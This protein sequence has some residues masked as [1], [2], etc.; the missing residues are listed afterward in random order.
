MFA[1]S[2][3]SP[4]KA[5]VYQDPEF[6]GCGFVFDDEPSAST[7]SV[8]TS[9][10][11]V[12]AREFVPKRIVEDEAAASGDEVASTH[13]ASSLSASAKEFVPMS[14]PQPPST[15]NDDSIYETRSCARCNK[16]Y[17]VFK[18]TGECCM[19]EPCVYH[20]GKPRSSSRKYSCC[21]RRIKANSSGCETAPSHVW[22]GILY[23]ISGRGLVT[24]YY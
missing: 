8:S 14:S 4:G 23:E 1:E 17:T 2:Q 22:R 15:L 19:P 9:S 18:D 16:L 12:N 10:L 21:G 3:L 13:S 20:W 6:R 24:F 5:W 7:K 11:D